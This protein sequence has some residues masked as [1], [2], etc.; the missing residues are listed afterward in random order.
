MQSPRHLLNAK[1][2]ALLAVILLGAL[3][4]IFVAQQIMAYR[5]YPSIPTK[6]PT[7][8]VD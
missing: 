1:Y 2:T 4:A 8:A 3:T 7:P 6:R 5:D